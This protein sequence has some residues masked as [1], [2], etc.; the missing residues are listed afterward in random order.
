MLWL[1]EINSAM[2]TH[3]KT[4]I[5]GV[6]DFYGTPIN[7]KAL[8]RL[9]HMELVT[10]DYPCVS[11]YNTGYREDRNLSDPNSYVISQL[12][13]NLIQKK[14]KAPNFIFSYQIDIWC[15]SPLERDSLTY[16][17]VKVILNI[18]CWI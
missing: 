7:A 13:N 16:E 15:K 6:E 14:A 3:V 8:L 4:L 5:G 17:W 18:L 12:E 11:I 9:P 2:L 1:R 10:E